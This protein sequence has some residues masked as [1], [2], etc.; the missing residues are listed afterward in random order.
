MPT[1]SSAYINE[2]IFL[3]SVESVYSGTDFLLKPVFLRGVSGSLQLVLLF[4]VYLMGVQ[5]IQG[6]SW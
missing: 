2:K 3:S 5:E 6:G 4:F 1:N